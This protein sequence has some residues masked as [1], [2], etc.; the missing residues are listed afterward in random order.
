ML[1][2][3]ADDDL[4]HAAEYRSLSKDPGFAVS[5]GQHQRVAQRFALAAYAGELATGYGITG[6]APGYATRVMIALFQRWVKGRGKGSHE[7]RQACSQ[8]EG[9]I[10]IERA[11]RF[12][13]KHE[14]LYDE[15]MRAGWFEDGSEGRVYHLVRGVFEGEVLKGLPHRRLK[16][17]LVRQGVL[18]ARGDDATYT[19]RV[20]ERNPFRLYHVSW[21][22]LQRLMGGA[23]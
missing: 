8:I 2:C 9:F 18:L 5:E 15:S 20:D 17:D 23:D 1:C 14:R 21:V 7:L 3:L 6:W 19:E 13:P 10:E 12:T 11:A 16:A 4:D 22:A